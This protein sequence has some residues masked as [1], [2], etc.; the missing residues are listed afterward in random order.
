MNT[1]SAPAL[2]ISSVEASPGE[3]ATALTLDELPV[4]AL[5]LPCA[6]CGRTAAAHGGRAPDCGGFV[7]P[8]LPQGYA[9]VDALREGDRFRFVSRGS[10]ECVR[11]A[12][13]EPSELDREMGLLQVR[14]SAGGSADVVHLVHVNTIV[15]LEAVSP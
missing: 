13:Q 12:A 1:T 7:Q 11:V 15:L 8:A 2:P 4:G 10:N 3:A 14:S 6:V 5:Q 9:Y